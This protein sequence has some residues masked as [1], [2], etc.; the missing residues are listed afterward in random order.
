MIH[1]KRIDEMLDT[2]ISFFVDNRNPD[3]TVDVPTTVI[4]DG[5][6]TNAEVVW[7]VELKK[8]YLDWAEAVATV[9]SSES[10]AYKVGDSVEIE[11]GEGDS[12]DDVADFIMQEFNR[13]NGR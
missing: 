3:K 9:K 11:I 1:I 5:G 12:I 7:S 8:D 4:E 13:T 2:L 10:D 6:R